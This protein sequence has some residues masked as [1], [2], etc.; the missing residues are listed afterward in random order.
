M[1]N[2]DQNM[3]DDLNDFFSL[4]SKAKKEKEEEIKKTREELIGDVDFGSIFSELAEIKKQDKKDQE[5][6]EK[7]EK[8]KRVKEKKQVE[9]LESWL[10]GESEPIQPKE[11]IVEEEIVEEKSEVESEDIIEEESIEE[12]VEEDDDNVDHALKILETIKS[13]EEV[14][15]N[16]DDPEIIKIRGELEYIKNLVNAQGGGGE[17]RLEFLDDIDRST[18]LIDG[19]FLKYDS[20]AG[21]WTGAVVTGGGGGGFSGDYNDLSNKPTIPTNNNELTNGA[22]YITTSFTNTN[23]LDNGAGFISTSVT[24]TN[25]L[26]NGAG[27][28]STSVTNNN[29]LTNGAGFISTSVTNNNQLTNGAGFITGISGIDT[30]GT[31]FFDQLNVTG[32]VGF[33]STVTFGDHDQIIMG[34]GPDLKLY[35]DGSNSYVEDSG[36]GALIMKGSTLRFRSTDDEKIINAHQNGSVDLFYDNVKRFETTDSGAVVTGTLVATAT[37]AEGLT[38]SPNITVGNLNVTGVNTSNFI[39][40]IGIGTTQSVS[41]SELEVYSDGFSNVRLLSRRTSG[42]QLIGGVGFSTIGADGTQETAGTINCRVDGDMIFQNAVESIRIHGSDGKAEFSQGLSFGDDTLD[43][44]DEGS[45]TPSYQ[46]ADDNIS[47]VNYDAQ[48]GHYT[49][50]GNMCYFIMRLR[51]SS[52]GNVGSGT[53]EVHGL[54]FTH[55]NNVSNRAVV[56][57]TTSGW[58]DGNA[59]TLG[60]FHQNTNT[61]KLTQK[62]ASQDPTNLSSSALNTSGNKNEIRVTGMYRCI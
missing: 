33:G 5:E 47:N 19:R 16:L 31:S 53:L 59:P 26:T 61:F 44:Y 10:Y 9:A 4:I 6:K 42:S 52:I 46:T 3:P 20:S 30:T 43:R 56:L 58:T 25:Q 49:R 36:T 23:Q 13:K 29:Q 48:A 11:E 8:I 41:S 22:G 40:N 28:I 55:V 1:A 34:D 35:H 39:G 37:T 60:L 2:A 17:V 18:A 54:P 38:G 32:G 21:I 15:E 7:N 27:F 62:S 57:L 50:I 51:T 45:F 14:R 24:N 12:K